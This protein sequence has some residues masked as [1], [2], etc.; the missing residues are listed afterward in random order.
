MDVINRAI[1]RDIDAQKANIGLK[2]NLLSYHQQKTDS[3]MNA[4]SLTKADMLDTSAALIEAR[5][6]QMKSDLA[7][8]QRR[9]EAQQARQQAAALRGQVS[10]QEIQAASARY[11]LQMQQ[12]KLRMISQMVQQRPE[13][14]PAN[15]ADNTQFLRTAARLGYV[16]E[17]NIAE[18]Q[19][20]MPTG[21][22]DQRTGAPIT[23]PK[24]VWRLFGNEKASNDARS[25]FQA[26]AS[27][28]PA[29]QRAKAILAQSS[30]GVHWLQDPRAAHQ[31][32]TDIANIKIGY[33]QATRGLSNQPSAGSLDELDKA[34]GN[35]G[36]VGDALWGG[37]LAALETIEQQVHERVLA[38]RMGAHY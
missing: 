7:G 17:G 21:T 36:G 30:T 11:E 10:L 34:L 6:T 35:P 31:L 38:T 32:H 2:R 15:G 23:V 18:E 24:T 26:A 28:T 5:A 14:H 27:I 9:I 20:Q 29:I 12:Y 3:L 4:M 19:V 8:P 13:D 33:E 22:I 37:S 16:A 25:V 1:D